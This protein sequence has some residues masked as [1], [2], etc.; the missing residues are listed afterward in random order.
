MGIVY[1]PAAFYQFASSLLRQRTPNRLIATNYFI[2]TVFLLLLPTPYLVN[3]DYTYFWGH[4]P[5][6]GLLH[7]LFLMYF[8]LVGG[9]S[10][11]RIYQEHLVAEIIN[12]SD[13]ARLKTLFWAFVVGYMAS[14]D[15]AQAYG[16]EF[17]PVGYVMAGLS[18]L[19]VTHTLMRYQD[20]DGALMPAAPRALLY[21]QTFGLIPVYV[22]VLLLIRLF[23]GTTQYLLTGILLA[24]FLIFAGALAGI[25]KRVE[26][27][28]AR[29]L[30]KQRHDA[31]ETLIQFSKA[32]VTILDLSSLS[33]T[34]MDTLARALG[35]EKISL[36]LQDK[37][38]SQYCLAAA[39]GLDFDEMK[40][41]TFGSEAEGG[42][43]WP[44]T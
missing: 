43:H 5:K 2:S 31:Y 33:G 1:I 22:T 38:K 3:G 7:P 40:T 13:A 34:I 9:W 20:M 26:Q 8:G 16:L 12:A 17:Y 11:Y 10:L 36:F 23:T 42:G 25:Q 4:Y 29:I 41:V 21:V 27:A 28:I 35:I 32:M 39:H 44:R 30:F 19:I 14:L 6:A 18:I 24:T 15:F 37:E